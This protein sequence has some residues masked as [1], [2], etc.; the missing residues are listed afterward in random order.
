VAVS[1][2]ERSLR[3]SL[4]PPASTTSGTS[5]STSA[6]GRTATLRGTFASTDAR[7]R[8]ALAAQISF[9]LLEHCLVR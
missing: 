8:P 7:P 6:L 1:L 5:R 3:W 2:H 4:A 9:V